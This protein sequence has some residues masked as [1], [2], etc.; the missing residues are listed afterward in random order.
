MYAVSFGLVAAATAHTYGYAVPVLLILAA[1]GVV[2]L[3][4]V[5][6]RSVG[7]FIPGVML[8]MPVGGSSLLL[9]VLGVAGVLL[10]FELEAVLLRQGPESGWA[11]LKPVGMHLGA[12]ALSSALAYGLYTAGFVLPTWSAVVALISLSVL[13]LRLGSDRS[14]TQ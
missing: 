12:I 8:M 7:A 11:T 4:R 13:F 2:L 6:L 14:D 3:R 5:R 1:C 10:M 9:R